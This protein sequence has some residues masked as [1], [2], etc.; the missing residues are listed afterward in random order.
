MERKTLHEVRDS[1]PRPAGSID[2]GPLEKKNHWIPPKLTELPRLNEI[3]LQS[4]GIPGGGGTG[5]G[6]S[7][8]VP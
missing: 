7:T 3:T 6:G 8:V 5:G 1:S 2:P 4:G